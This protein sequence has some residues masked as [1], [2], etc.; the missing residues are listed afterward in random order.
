MP[1]KGKAAVVTGS[2]SGIGQAIALAFAGEGCNVMLNGFGDAAAIEKQRLDMESRFGVK[3]AYHGADMS[4]P[5]QIADL[6]AKSPPDGYTICILPADVLQYNRHVIR[7][8]NYDM[9]TDLEPV[10]QLFFLTQGLV[11][12]SK[13]N[14]STLDELVA[15]CAAGGAD[16]VAVGPVYASTTKSGHAD[17]VGV[18]TLRALVQASSL[19]V[20]AIGG[21]TTTERIAD[22]ARSGATLRVIPQVRV[23]PVTG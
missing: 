16:H 15:A 21:V 14:V 1:L 13:L 5:S 3:V 12:S 6:V 11:V 9:F 10:T 4:K 8:L 17:V 23:T 2:T 7:N 20:V 18:D 19:P 22:V